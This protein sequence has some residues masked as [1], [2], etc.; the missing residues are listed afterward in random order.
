MLRPS[1]PS[2]FLCLC[3]S[4][5]IFYFTST[6]EGLYIQIPRCHPIE[7]P[8]HSSLSSWVIPFHWF[9]PPPIIFLM[10]W[11][12]KK[13]GE[14]LYYEWSIPWLELPIHSSK[15]LPNVDWIE[16]N[17]NDRVIIIL[18]WIELNRQYIEEE[19]VYSPKKYWMQLRLVSV[20]LRCPEMNTFS[21]MWQS[22]RKWN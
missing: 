22:Q 15:L 21:E 6:S 7:I 19:K 5:P 8:F 2:I 20:A 17:T 9:S 4:K 11:E 13:L 10:W 1:F 12:K 16:A 18:Y 3:K 14:T